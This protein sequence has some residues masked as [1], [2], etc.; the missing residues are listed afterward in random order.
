MV[1]RSD[2]RG[3]NEASAM[4][5]YALRSFAVFG[6]LVLIGCS[7][8]SGGSTTSDFDAGP[9]VDR[10]LSSS[11]MDL[12][13]ASRADAGPIE[14]NLAD[15]RVAMANCVVT[16]ECL[17]LALSGDYEQ[18]A[19]CVRDCFLATPSGGISYDCRVC[20][21]YWLNCAATHCTIECLGAAS[22]DGGTY[23]LCYSCALADCQADLDLC[24]GY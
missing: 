18:A 22:L 6:A 17:P 13:L 24:V 5:L 1:I 10:C 12:I 8:G 14:D 19:L 4:F 2:L 20:Y 3:E 7:T 16:P 9:L 21:Y 15:P 23:D 11:D